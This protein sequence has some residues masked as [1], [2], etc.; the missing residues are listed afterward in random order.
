MIERSLPYQIHGKDLHPEFPE[1]SQVY[2]L[3]L[4]A[5]FSTVPP[6]S[7]PKSGGVVDKVFVYEYRDGELRERTIG[8]QIG[9]Q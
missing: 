8:L 1:G 2:I 7:L 6:A 3:V 9:N 5:K 4:S